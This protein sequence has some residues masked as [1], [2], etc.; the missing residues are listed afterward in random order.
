MRLLKLFFTLS[1]LVICCICSSGNPNSPSKSQAISILSLTNAEID[2]WQNSDL[3]FF[4]EIPEYTQTLKDTVTLENEYVRVMQNKASFA[5][6]NSQGFGTRIIVA[7][8][9]LDFISSKG[10]VKLKRG[11]IAVF[12]VQESYQPPVGAF[13]E[14]AFKT[15]HPALKA[16]EQWIEPQG[17]TI[18]YEDSLIRVFEERLGPGET[19]D[20]HSHAQR[21]VVRLNKVQLTDPRF[22]PEGSPS[23]GI[24][25]PNTVK[26]AEPMV[27][28]VRNLSKET[29]LFNVVI[30][31][32][33]PE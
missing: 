31:F 10:G 19:R 27:H 28:V 20:L 14:V 2:H 25:V 13:F 4:I 29:P 22:K 7:L 23:G 1:F 17:N 3:D 15:N 30:E 33:L 18:V 11:G 12:Q 21:V 8:D 24:Q 32:K 9:D 16:P 6:A 5:S 26:F